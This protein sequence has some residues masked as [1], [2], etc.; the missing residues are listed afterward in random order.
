MKSLI[1]LKVTFMKLIQLTER[2]KLQSETLLEC[3]GITPQ[4]SLIS[5]KN[6]ELFCYETH[7]YTPTHS[8]TE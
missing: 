2:E 4:L 1:I 6:G 8:L 7:Y 5:E 3:V